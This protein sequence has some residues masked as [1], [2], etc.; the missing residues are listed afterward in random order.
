MKIGSRAAGGSTRDDDIDLMAD[1][2]A[3][4][5]APVVLDTAN[6]EVNRQAIEVEVQLVMGGQPLDRFSAFRRPFLQANGDGSLRCSGMF[7]RQAFHDPQLGLVYKM[8]PG[9]KT[10]RYSSPS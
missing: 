5:S 7:L 2:Q 8:P 1:G 10:W 3:R 9:N 4:P 6:G